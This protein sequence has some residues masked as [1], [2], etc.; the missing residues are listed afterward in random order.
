VDKRNTSERYPRPGEIA[1]AAVFFR[2]ADAS[3][4][5]GQAGRLSRIVTTAARIVASIAWTTDLITYKRVSNALGTI[6]LY[7]ESSKPSGPTCC[8]QRQLDSRCM[9]MSNRPAEHGK[10]GTKPTMQ[11]ACLRAGASHRENSLGDFV[12]I[13]FCIVLARL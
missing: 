7:R 5:T 13:A 11:E 9:R 2:L 8:G 3:V 4:V 12:A 1:G 6:R 10:P